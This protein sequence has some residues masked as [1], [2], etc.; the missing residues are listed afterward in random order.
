MEQIPGHDRW[1]TTPEYREGEH[2][3]ACPADQ[4]PRALC[5]CPQLEHD[6]AMMAAEAMM[7]M[8]RGN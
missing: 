8:R 1:K 5:I 3:E 6:A 4:D 7:D 2:F